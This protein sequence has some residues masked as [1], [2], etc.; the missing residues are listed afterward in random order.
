MDN[1]LLQLVQMDFIEV[2]VQLMINANLALL[3]NIVR[4]VMNCLQE[5][6]AKNVKILIRLLPMEYAQNNNVLLELK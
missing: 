1:V 3:I 4:H 2:L 6:N 5:S